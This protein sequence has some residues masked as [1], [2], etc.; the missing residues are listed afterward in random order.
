MIEV[1]ASQDLLKDLITQTH[2][3]NIAIIKGIPSQTSSN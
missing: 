3:Q 1:L 2:Y